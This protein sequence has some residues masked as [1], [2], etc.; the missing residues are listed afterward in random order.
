[1]NTYTLVLLLAA[2]LAESVRRTKEL[3]LLPK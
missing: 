3:D 1:M 2:E